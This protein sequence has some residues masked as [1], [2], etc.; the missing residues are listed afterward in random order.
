[1]IFIINCLQKCLWIRAVLLFSRPRSTRV[2]AKRSGGHARDSWHF[3]AI[4]TK[5][6]TSPKKLIFHKKLWRRH[7]VWRGCELAATPP[8]FR[9]GSPSSWPRPSWVPRS[10]STRDD[11]IL[12]HRRFEI[13]NLNLLLGC[14][15]LS[16]SIYSCVSKTWSG[17]YKT[18][19]LTRI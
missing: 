6:Y 3:Q 18:D 4:N 2:E 13:K 1:M 9:S 19:I 12:I 7:S 11:W 10:S 8:C 14:W 5:V 17:T 16:W 15:L